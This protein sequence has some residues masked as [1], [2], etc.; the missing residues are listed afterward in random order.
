MVGKLHAPTF[1]PP[2]HTRL[3][4]PHNQS[5]RS[6]A[7]SVII[8]V[9][10]RYFFHFKV[11]VSIKG[12]S[13]L[14]HQ[15]IRDYV[16]HYVSNLVSTPPFKEFASRF[17][18]WRTCFPPG[19]RSFTSTS[20]GVMVHRNRTFSDAS[21]QEWNVFIRM[22]GECLRFLKPSCVIWLVLLTLSFS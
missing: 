8:P 11:H 14:Y 18:I 7:S 6:G 12:A 3:S 10:R 2:V 22:G 13:C 17:S 16:N 21:L 9:T 5:G 19:P 20:S 1:L 4:G 15:L